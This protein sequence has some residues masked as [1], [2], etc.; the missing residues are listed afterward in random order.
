MKERYFS[1]DP[2]QPLVSAAD[3][4]SLMTTLARIGNNVNQIAR[5]VNA[6]LAFDVF[7][8]VQEVRLALESERGVWGVM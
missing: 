6:G 1:C 8:A 7:A 2:V 4:K 5:R 3:L